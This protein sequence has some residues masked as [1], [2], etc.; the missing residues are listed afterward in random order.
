MDAADGAH[1]RGETCG[2]GSN[3]VPN[4]AS[5][6]LFQV[7]TGECKRNV[8]DGLRHGASY[9]CT[10]IIQS[11]QGTA[12]VAHGTGSILERCLD[13][14]C[15]ASELVDAI[16]R[17]LDFCLIR[18]PRLSRCTA[19]LL[20]Q[21]FKP[22]QLVFEC[23]QRGDGSHV[24]GLRVERLFQ[25]GG[26]ATRHAG[27]H[28]HRL[29]LRRVELLLARHLVERVL[30]LFKLLLVVIPH[31]FAGTL[32]Q[33]RQPLHLCLLCLDAVG[34]V[35]YL[36]A[37]LASTFAATATRATA[38]DIADGRTFCTVDGTVGLADG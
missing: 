20:L 28:R 9:L 3:P 24:D 4:I 19:K 12:E 27:T 32:P 35:V 11:R 36:G 37:G 16:L 23:F 5:F 31:G 7:G 30:C 21:G 15:V 34:S 1:H 8:C 13:Y 26:H 29:H 6:A 22:C 2:R 33:L 10:R 14:F 25:V 38:H 18:L 17:L